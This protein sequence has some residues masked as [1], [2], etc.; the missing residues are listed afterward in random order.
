MKRTLIRPDLE[1]IPA[2][3]HPLLSGAAVYDSSCS[4]EARVLYIESSGG[5]FLKS[6]PKGALQREA[7]LTSFFHEKH[8]AAEVLSYCSLDR[9]WL[10]TSKVPGEDCIH[11]QY[12]ADPKRLCE[13]I[14]VHLRQ[15]HDL[16][17]AGCPIPDHTG[18][19]LATAASNHALGT[20]DPSRLPPDFHRLS[21]CEVWHF[22]EKHASLLKTDTLIHG[23]YCLPNIMLDDWRFSGFIDLDHGG[24]GDRHIDLYW[25][26]WSLEFNLKSNQYRDRFLDAYGRDIVDD[27]LLQLIACIE[28]F[29]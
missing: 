9:D 22:V 24:V 25:G 4:P 8:L 13:T 27:N 17:T 14:A 19:Y 18:M 12:L 2:V 20:F 21:T 29:G 5:Y 23:D 16:P 1:Q 11:A 28:A 3:F 7:E 6:A 26:L 15:L 10:L